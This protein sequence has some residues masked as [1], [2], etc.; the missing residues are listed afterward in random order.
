VLLGRGQFEYTELSLIPKLPVSE[1]L[2]FNVCAASGSRSNARAETLKGLGVVQL[3]S[4]S[5]PTEQ[6]VDHAFGAAVPRNSGTLASRVG[7]CACYLL[8]SFGVTFLC[9]LVLRCVV[10]AAAYVGFVP[11]QAL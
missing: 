3:L 6:L 4:E 10:F 8:L 5:T 7:K 2:R 9:F 1:E 11:A